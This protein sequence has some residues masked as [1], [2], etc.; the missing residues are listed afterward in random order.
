[1]NHYLVACTKV[2]SKWIKD[3][4]ARLG[5]IKP[6]EEN[7]DG[8]LLDTGLREDIFFHLIPKAAKAKINK[9]TTLN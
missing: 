5:S 3:L 6:L 1:M 9:R 7:I 2:K 4:N 8:K